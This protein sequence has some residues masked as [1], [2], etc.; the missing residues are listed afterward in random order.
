[1]INNIAVFF[2]KN[3]APMFVREKSEICLGDFLDIFWPLESLH[4]PRSQKGNGCKT[5]SPDN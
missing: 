3:N 4:L 1:M 5:H 2:P